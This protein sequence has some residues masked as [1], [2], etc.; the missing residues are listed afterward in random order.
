[1]LTQRIAP[2]IVREMDSEHKG[3]RFNI[4]ERVRGVNDFDP[5]R[6]AVVPITGTEGGFL[7]IASDGMATLFFC[8]TTISNL[9]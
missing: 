9:S 3:V 4:L 1:M 7:N 6:L 5:K 2:G 8:K